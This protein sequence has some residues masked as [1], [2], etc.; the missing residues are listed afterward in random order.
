MPLIEQATHQV[1]VLAHRYH[2]S[3]VQWHSS[4]SREKSIK[5]IVNST[6]V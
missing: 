5:P 2:M 4:P 3:R 1:T 6:A